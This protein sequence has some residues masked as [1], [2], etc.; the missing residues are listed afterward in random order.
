MVAAS[1]RIGVP[2]PADSE[3][4]GDRQLV[5]RTG[6]ARAHYLHFRAVADLACAA[7]GGRQAPILPSCRLAAGPRAAPLFRRANYQHLGD[8]GPVPLHRDR[9]II[10]DLSR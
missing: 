2:H 1:D 6:R 9:S 5:H 8:R 3:P 7:V 10:M 4:A